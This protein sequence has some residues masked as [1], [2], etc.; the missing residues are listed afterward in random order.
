MEGILIS[1]RLALNLDG[2][3]VYCE[4]VTKHRR[5]AKSNSLKIRTLAQLD[6]SGQAVVVASD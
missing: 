1:A 5:D 3:V 6:V 4:S 2:R